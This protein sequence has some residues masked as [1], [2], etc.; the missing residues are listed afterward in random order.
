MG[1]GACLW[2]HGRGFWRAS[3][4][5]VMP[6]TCSPRC[7]CCAVLCRVGTSQLSGPALGPAGG[8]RGAGLADA[9]LQVPARLCSSR[10]AAPHRHPCGIPRRHALHPGVNAAAASVV[11]N[12]SWC[13]QRVLLTIHPPPVPLLMQC[14]S[15]RWCAGASAA[16]LQWRLSCMLCCVTMV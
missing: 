1:D 15:T 2:L 11:W 13:L 5:F 10:R 4:K 7:P 6:L 12:V 3:T 8:S 9:A 16:A 14:Q